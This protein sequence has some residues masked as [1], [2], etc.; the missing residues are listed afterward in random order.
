[1]HT[2]LFLSQSVE[3]KKLDSD[4]RLSALND[5][6]K[7]YQTE[8]DSAGKR[9][10]FAENC[11]LNLY[12]DLIQLPDPY[13]FLSSALDFTTQTLDLQGENEKL[14]K[15]IESLLMSNSATPAL[16]ANASPTSAV[17][18]T[19]SSSA[20][21]PADVIK[22]EAKILA[23]KLIQ[24]KELDLESKYE[25]KMQLLHDAQVDQGI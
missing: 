2:F 18:A 11:F 17:D 16:S 8:I 9:C 21:V 23:D 14:K 15:Q 24:E 22:T 13:P 10:K 19:S 12:K 6:L 20:L 7:S 3:F 5:L 4:E 25:E 1:M